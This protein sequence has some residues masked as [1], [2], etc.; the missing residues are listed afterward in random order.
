LNEEN[1]DCDYNPEDLIATAKVLRM[2][3][4]V[5]K[6]AARTMRIY[7]EARTSVAGLCSARALVDIAASASCAL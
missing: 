1:P 7:T 6:V 5:L 4:E 2:R 3:A